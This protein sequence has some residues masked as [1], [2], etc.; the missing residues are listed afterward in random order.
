MV[1]D[2]VVRALDSPGLLVG[3]EGDD[4]VAL[5]LL[6]LAE[7]VLQRGDDH[8]I[9][10]LHVDGATT[11]EHAVLDDAAEGVDGPIGRICRDH[12]EVAVNDERRLLGVAPLHPCD[13]AGAP[14]V[15]VEELR[16][17][18]E[19]AQVLCH[20]LGG[21]CLAVRPA[22][23]VVRGVEADEVTRNDG[24][25]VELRNIVCRRITGL[26]HGFTLPDRSRT[27]RVV[28]PVSRTLKNPL[29]IRANLV[30][31]R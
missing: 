4:E 1:L 23:A 3:E 15:G 6:P 24:S 18:A 21:L 12:V 31:G 20:V 16:L 30:F 22:L 27:R 28:R 14:G 5:R 17:Q 19:R 11:P 13:D 9:H 29:G 2:Q 25:G 8:G 7:D 10:V 26:G